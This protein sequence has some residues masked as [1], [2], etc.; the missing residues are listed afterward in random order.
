E[1]PGDGPRFQEVAAGDTRQDGV[2]RIAYGGDDRR[3][4]DFRCRQNTPTEH[5]DLSSLSWCNLDKTA[6]NGKKPRVQ[7][8]KKSMKARRAGRIWRRLG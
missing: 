8:L 7:T 3:N 5:D 2:L 1:S 4:P 6:L